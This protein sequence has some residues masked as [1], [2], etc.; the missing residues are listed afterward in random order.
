MLANQFPDADIIDYPELANI[1]GGVAFFDSAGNGCLAVPVH[2]PDAARRKGRRSFSEV[3][4]C[5]R[6]T[7]AAWGVK[8]FQIARAAGWT[9][10]AATQELKKHAVIEVDSVRA[11]GRRACPSV[12]GM[13][14][15]ELDKRLKQYVASLKAS[16]GQDAVDTLV[17][18]EFTTFGRLGR[19]HLRSHDFDARLYEAFYGRLPGSFHD[20]MADAL[21]PRPTEMRFPLPEAAH[22]SFA[23]GVNLAFLWP[24][25]WLYRLVLG[26]AAALNAWTHGKPACLMPE[27][28]YALFRCVGSAVIDDDAEHEVVKRFLARMVDD[29][30]GD[31]AHFLQHAALALNANGL[32]PEHPHTVAELMRRSIAIVDED[33]EPEIFAVSP[34]R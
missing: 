15:S 14:A 34:L 9:L 7:M 20:K 17:R 29:L 10:E 12:F 22:L 23:T 25:Q 30:Y 33:G 18:S 1:Y 27:E 32:L 13:T 21:N 31:R 28:F 2:E 5:I 16:E 24:E 4:L 8:A 19:V 26:A 6:D 3:Q 11:L